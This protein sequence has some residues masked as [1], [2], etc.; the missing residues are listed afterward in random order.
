MKKEFLSQLIFFSKYITYFYF[1]NNNNYSRKI[2]IHFLKSHILI[3]IFVKVSFFYINLISIFFYRKKFK[4]LRYKQ[5]KKILNFLE[6]I[7]ILQVPKIIELFHALSAIHLCSNENETIIKPDPKTNK[8]YYENIVIGSGPGGSITANE[9]KKSGKEVLLIE[10]GD[11]VNHFKLKH[12]GNELLKKWQ[13]G[14]LAVALG[15]IKIQYALAKCFGGGSEINSGLYHEPDKEFL[16]TWRQKFNT[17]K[18]SYEEIKSF[19]EITKKKTN[20]TCLD[21]FPLITDKIISAANNN[22]WKIEEVPRWVDLNNNNNPIKKSMTQTYL[23]EYLNN[24]GEFLLNS[25]VDKIKKV[26][27]LWS[28]K[29]KSKKNYT[30]INCKHVFLCCGSINNLSLLNKSKLKTKN[31]EINLHP[32]VKVIVKFPNEVNNENMEIL[33]HQIT[34]FFPKFLIGNA[35]SGIQFLRTATQDDSNFYEEV[36]KDWKNMLIFHA[37]FSTGIGKVFNFPFLDDP[38]V[39]YDIKNKDLELIKEGM[40]KLSQ[41]MFEAG[42][43]FIYPIIK[44]PIKLYANNFNQH[45]NKIKNISRFNFSAVHVLGG[46]PMGE[47]SNQCLVNSFGEMHNYKN[48]Y[49]NDSS[50]ICNKLLKNP[51]GTTMAIAL[52]NITNFLKQS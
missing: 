47:D 19:I 14:G 32:M 40:I 43:E 51:Q 26:K 42:G 27:D 46:A 17:E 5:F 13:Y 2:V 45:I 28:L 25:T 20:V 36:K 10:S 3:K 9:L 7:S 24:K 33:T 29:V 49:I 8:G 22:N 11:W 16:N 4:N 37:T 44:N 18:I 12:P 34:E 41:L 21:K 1:N 38:V 23:K 31:S 52:R 6:K 48:L 39:Q 35:A 30:N 50:L 15:N